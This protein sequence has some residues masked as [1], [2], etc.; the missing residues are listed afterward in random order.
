MLNIFWLC[1]KYTFNVVQNTLVHIKCIGMSQ[2][3]TKLQLNLQLN[4]HN[5]LI[6]DEKL[7]KL[8]NAER[9]TI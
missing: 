4:E 5:N 7:K 6:L 2:K 9:C 8:I 3:V 1:V